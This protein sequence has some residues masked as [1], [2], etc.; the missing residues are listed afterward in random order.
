MTSLYWDSDYT[1][2]GYTQTGITIDWP[3]KVIFVPRSELTLVQNSPTFIYELDLDFFR[4]ELR[5]LEDDYEG[6]PFPRTHK[7]NTQSSVSGITLARVIEI[8]NDYTVTFEDGQYAVNLIGANSNV[9]D[10]VNVNQVS[11]RPSNSAGL[12]VAG[13]GL[14]SSQDSLLTQIHQS[15]FNKRQWNKVNNTITIYDA[16]GTTPLYVFDTNSDL[17]EITPQ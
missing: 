12:I 13:S 1:S 6:M 4:R 9:A 2:S 16:D 17:S 15:Q 7:H 5:A 8:V 3:D 10:R 11:V 14:D